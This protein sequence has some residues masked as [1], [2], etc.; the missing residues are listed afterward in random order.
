MQCSSMSQNTPDF[1]LN[2][3]APKTDPPAWEQGRHCLG[4]SA[5]ISKT[6]GLAA[7]HSAGESTLGSVFHSVKC[8]VVIQIV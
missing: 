7:R 8:F 5:S 2:F 3:G 6:V 4:H 1:D